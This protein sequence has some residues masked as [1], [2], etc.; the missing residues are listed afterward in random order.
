M[1]GTKVRVG[2]DEKC[3]I[4]CAIQQDREYRCEE[5]RFEHKDHPSLF[6]RITRSPEVLADEFV[7]C[8][9]PERFCECADWR[10]VILGNVSFATRY[11]AFAAT[12]EKL[13]EVGK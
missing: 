12:L 3:C 6:Y 9:E 5:C 1:K 10:S 2:K 8:A 4:N 11:E 13:K 7:Y